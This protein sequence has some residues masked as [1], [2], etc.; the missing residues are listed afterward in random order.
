[1]AVLPFVNTSP[2][3]SDNYLGH[4][5]AAELT[6][7]LDRIPGLRVAARSSAFGLNRRM[8]ILA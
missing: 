1:M 8:A 2:D 5:I 7:T 4:G 3:I 6:R